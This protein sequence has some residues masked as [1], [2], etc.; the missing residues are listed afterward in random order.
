LFFPGGTEL[1]YFK[2]TFGKDIEITIAIAG[3]KAKYPGA[4]GAIS[5]EPGAIASEAVAEGA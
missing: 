1:L 2:L 3:E 4:S 5:V